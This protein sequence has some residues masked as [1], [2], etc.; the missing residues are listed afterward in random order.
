MDPSFFAQ[1]INRREI[2]G[3]SLGISKTGSGAP[4]PRGK[5]R[6]LPLLPEQC[7]GKHRGKRAFFGMNRTFKTRVLV[8]TDMNLH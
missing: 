8:T 3:A 6:Q 7:G 4:E 2:L 1:S 5:R